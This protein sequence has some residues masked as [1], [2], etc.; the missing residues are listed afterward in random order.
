MGMRINEDAH[1]RMMR[2]IEANPDI[3][4][5]RL[6]RELGISLG[7]VNYCLNALVEKGFV[8]M[9]RFRR[10]ETKW[11]YAYVLTPKGLS[12]KAKLTRGFLSRKM[13]EYEMLK[14]EIASIEAELKGHEGY[15]PGRRKT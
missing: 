9:E 14:K 8:K 13:A 3:S 5:R 7:G 11:A 2:L 10:S 12:Q 6:S 15:D 4:Q 1:Y